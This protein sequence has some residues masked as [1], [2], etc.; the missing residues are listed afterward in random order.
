MTKQVN[1]FAGLNGMIWW[2]GVVESRSDPLNLGRCQVRIFGWHTDNKQLIPTSDL[3][4]ALPILPSNNANNFSTPKEGEYVTG[5][6][7]DAESGQFPIMFG[8]L[9][10]IITNNTEATATSESKSDAG[11]QDPRTPEEI[12]SA[13]KPPEDQIQREIG[14]PTTPPLARG[15]VV[16]TALARAAKNRS[17][18]CD[19]VAEFTYAIAKAKA[20][21]MGI[22]KSIRDA[23]LGPGVTPIIEQIKSAIN[24]IKQKIKMII[25]ALKPIIDLVKAIA[26]YIKQIMQIIK[27]IMSLPAQLIKLLANCLKQAEADLAGLQ[28]T[29]TEVNNSS[30]DTLLSS[31][32]GLTTT[33]T[34]LTKTVSTIKTAAPRLG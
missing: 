2:M 6:F 28:S 30:S 15:Q 17:H 20:D 21:I 26:N 7:A 1:N 19:T 18:N 31:V 16:N 10:G 4:W 14:K 5:F 33:I 24:T 3:P 12:Q 29:Q 23:I 32:S 27:Y 8:V 11:F 9:P 13:P 22:I 34:T 25:K